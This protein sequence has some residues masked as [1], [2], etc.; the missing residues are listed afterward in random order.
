MMGFGH[1]N[2][3][4]LPENIPALSSY[5][6]A[7]ALFHNR[8]PYKR[9]DKK[10]ERAL[11]TVRKY[12]RSLIHLH[13]LLDDKVACSYYGT[14][15][16]SFYKDGRIE[17]RTGG[18]P[19]IST[20]LFI[21][22]VLRRTPHSVVR[23]HNKL[24]Y[25]DSKQDQYLCLPSESAV[26]LHPDGRIDGAQDEFQ[27]TLSKTVMRELRKKYAEF[28][29]YGCDMLT[30][31][32]DVVVEEGQTR[33]PQVDKRIIMWDRGTTHPIRRLEFFHAI[34]F[35][36]AQDDDA[37]LQQYFAL[38]SSVAWSAGCRVWTGSTHS[39]FRRCK[40]TQ[41]KKAMETLIKLQYADKLF[42][43]E[44]ASKSK[45]VFDSNAFYV[46]CGNRSTQSI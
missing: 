15:V 3:S 42:I 35:A 1:G 33:V 19:S 37:K 4:Q 22:A 24:Y 18:Y 13:P 29:R 36:M 21:K 8:L 11:G 25:Y 38:M 6:D 16:V 43:K 7:V 17:L 40:P 30:M 2:H 9:G 10:G 12:N 31:N 45:P 14:E 44:E 26:T 5:A 28:L 46:A 34:N 41:F 32:Q 23:K 27:H 39:E 20:M